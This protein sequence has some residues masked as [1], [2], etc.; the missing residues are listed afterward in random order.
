MDRGC[1]EFL[2]LT[3]PLKSLM[4]LS[5]EDYARALFA[6]LGRLN[7]RESAVIGTR[8]FGYWRRA[9]AG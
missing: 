6:Y 1:P 7:E 8:T 4:L 3:R 5:L 2:R 9:V